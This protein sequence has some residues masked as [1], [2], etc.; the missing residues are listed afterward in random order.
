LKK[1]PFQEGFPEGALATAEQSLLT[2]LAAF[3]RRGMVMP[4]Q[5]PQLATDRGPAVL[6]GRLLAMCV[7]PFAAWRR[8]SRPGRFAL[9]FGYA[10]AGYAATFGALELAPRLLF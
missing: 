8:S 1:G 2:R 7:H 6:F 5:R 4:M 9:V 10:A 3:L